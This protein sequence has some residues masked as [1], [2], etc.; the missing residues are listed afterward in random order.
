MTRKLSYL[1]IFLIVL[2]AACGSINRATPSSMDDTAMKTDVK[3][4]ILETDPGKTFD[5][6]VEVHDGIVTLN[7]DVN[8]AA[9]R[10]EIVRAANSVHGVKRVIDNIQLKR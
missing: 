1:A 2:S 7:G 10:D 8:T 6:G 9:E 5:I 3:G 4:K